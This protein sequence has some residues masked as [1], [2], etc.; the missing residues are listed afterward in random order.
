MRLRLDAYELAISS[1][2]STAERV[3][4]MALLAKVAAI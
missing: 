1:R 3:Q 2:L 4:L